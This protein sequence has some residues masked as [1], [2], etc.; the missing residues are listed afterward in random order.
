MLVAGCQIHYVI[1]TDNV[2]TE[3]VDI[4][5]DHEGKRHPAKNLTSRIYNADLEYESSKVKD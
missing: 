1:Q 4:E 3:P 2:N 5:V